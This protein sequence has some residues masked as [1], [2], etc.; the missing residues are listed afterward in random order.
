MNKP[1]SGHQPYDLRILFGPMFGADIMISGDNMFFCVGDNTIDDRPTDENIENPAEHSLD[2]AAHT[3]YIPYQAGQPNFRVRFTFDANDVDNAAEITDPIDFEVDFLYPDGSETQRG[4]LNSICLSGDIAFAIKRRDDEWSEAVSSYALKPAQEAVESCAPAENGEPPRSGNPTLRFAAKLA[5]VLL[6][7]AGLVGL[8]YWQVQRYIGAQKL[9]SV[10]S[11]LAGA[12]TRNVVLPGNDGK[13][14]V[15]TDT[16]DGAEWDEQALFKAALPEPTEVDVLSAE[17]QRIEHRLDT[18][19]I[20]FITVRLDTPASPVLVVNANLSPITRENATRELR[21]ATP[22]AQQVRMV[23]TDI[24]VVEREARGLLDS[25]GVRYRRLARRDGATFE[26][27]DSLSD[28]EL[29]ALQNLI[30][31]FSKK[32]GTHRVDFKIALRTDWLKGKSYRE[33]GEGYVLL[34]HASWYFPKPLKGVN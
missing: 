13:I 20:S 2:Y 27:A 28:E 18:A 34:D 10:N 32:W 22:Y 30:A 21:R 33:G 31:S 16:Q 15:L 5:V 25:V 12:P 9:A 29:A 24:R 19:G 17:R 23:G 1:D 3:L 11:L 26:V 6:V 7:G 8:T 4:V 14:Y